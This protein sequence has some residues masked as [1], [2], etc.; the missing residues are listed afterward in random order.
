MPIK[1]GNIP[2]TRVVFMSERRLLNLNRDIQ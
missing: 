1:E 2:K